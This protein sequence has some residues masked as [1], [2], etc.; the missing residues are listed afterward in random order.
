MKITHRIL[1]VAAL[2]MAVSAVEP[3]AARAQAL[4]QAT[5]A[6]ALERIT[7]E[8][9]RYSI[10][11]PRGYTSKTSPRPDGGTMQ[12]L[13]YLWKDSVGQFNVVA[14]SIV[15]PPPGSTKQIDIREVQRIIAARYP[16]SLLA[17]AQDIQTGPAKGIAFDMTINSNRGQGQH[18]V[19]MRIYAMGGRLY[20]LQAATRTEDRNDPTVTAFM[21]SLQVMR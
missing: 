7:G 19:A 13:T 5:Q 16:G 17:N 21:N 8:D 3:T 12:M 4:A 6:P 18:V 2:L 9:G 15:D 10:D 11:M 20:E 1:G 14:L